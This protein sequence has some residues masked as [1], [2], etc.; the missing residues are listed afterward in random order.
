ME[1]NIAEPMLEKK[2]CSNVAPSLGSGPPLPYKAKYKGQISKN[3]LEAITFEWSVLGTPSLH[4]QT[5]F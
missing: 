1:V 3:E 5:T 4:L 2:F